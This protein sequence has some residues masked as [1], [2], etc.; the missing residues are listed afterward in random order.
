[1]IS[2]LCDIYDWDLYKENLGVISSRIY[3]RNHVSILGVFC[4]LGL[5][6]FNHVSYV[7][8]GCRGTGVAYS[9]CHT[10]PHLPNKR[11]SDSA[12]SLTFELLGVTY[13]VGKMKFELLF[14]GPKWL[15]KS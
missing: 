7:R 8:C 3:I 5:L 10:D 14:D 13:L 15:S 12:K 4:M 9:A 11:S 1:M 2:I 6:H